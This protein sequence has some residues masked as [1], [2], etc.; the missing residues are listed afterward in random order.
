[1]IHEQIAPAIGDAIVAY[2]ENP[3]AFLEERFVDERFVLT[4]RIIG[5]ISQIGALAIAEAA[6]EIVAVLAQ[7]SPE[8]GFWASNECGMKA[9]TRF[10]PRPRLYHLWA[11][12]QRYLLDTSDNAQTLPYERQCS[13]AAV[14]ADYS[15][16]RLLRGQDECRNWTI[17]GYFLSHYPWQF[18]GPRALRSLSDP[19]GTPGH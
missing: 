7:Q 1:M 9:P 18:N 8:P 10:S 5:E 3:Q 12:L 14:V 15:Q 11:E 17:Q 19:E 16:L 4:R 6:R 13:D 2:S